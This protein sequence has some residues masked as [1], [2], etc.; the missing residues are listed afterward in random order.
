MGGHGRFHVDAQGRELA[1][2]QAAG[3]QC[4]GV[5][6]HVIAQGGPVAEDDAV[7][8]GAAVGVQKPGDELGLLAAGRSLQFQLALARDEAQPGEA[9]GD[10]AQA[11]HALQRGIPAVGLVAVHLAE[12]LPVVGA[13]QYPF[14]LVCAVLRRGKIPLGRQAGMD[15]RETETIVVVEQGTVAQ[16]VDQ[17]VPVGCLEHLVQVVAVL[18]AV[19]AAGQCQQVQVVVSQHGD[20]PLTEGLHQPQGLQGLGT[21]VYQVAHEPEPITGRIETDRLQQRAQFVVASLDVADRIDSH[22]S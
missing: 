6:G 10:E 7:V 22:F 12:E 14:H 1:T 3:V 15:Q 17:L 20:G 16:P 5:L 18:E 19:V 4:P 2:P 9:V 8:P 21:A 13:A 11:V